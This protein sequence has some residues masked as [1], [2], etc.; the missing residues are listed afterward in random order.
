MMLSNSHFDS[1]LQGV[2]SCAVSDA[3]DRLGISGV[4]D[5]IWSQTGPQQR[6]AGKVIT[7]RVVPRTDNKPRPHLCTGA[8]MSSD[9]GDVIVVDNG[10][11]LDVS[12]WGG[13]LSQAAVQQQVAGVILEGAC[14]DVTEAMELGFP[15]FA[16]G[17]TP[18]TARGRIVEESFGEPVLI[19]GLTVATGD[20][21]IADP[22]GIAF[23][24]KTRID[25]VVN[26]ANRIVDKE[27]EMAQSLKYGKSIIDIMHDQQF[28]QI[29]TDK[30]A[31]DQPF[32]RPS[33]RSQRAEPSH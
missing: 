14:R 9:P 7:V 32:G 3:M 18:R 21:V 4:V 8:I 10:G 13:L 27:S 24:P 11:R 23:V 29:T 28:D 22:T 6:I 17:T 15:V 2:D 1:L 20:Y 31:K 33:H 5:G 26:L 25:E 16:K 30:V 19:S 12:C